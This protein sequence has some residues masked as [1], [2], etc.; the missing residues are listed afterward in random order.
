MIVREQKKLRLVNKCGAVCSETLL[1]AALLDYVRKNGLPP[2]QSHKTVFMH[3]KYPAVSVHGKKIHIHRLI[4][5]FLS[6]NLDGK[7]VD[8]INGNK[9]D[10]RVA[11]L[12][13]LTP[14]EHQR[15]TNLG[16]KQSP[17]HIAKRTASMK[18]TRYENHE[19]LEAKE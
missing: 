11:N 13:L 10:A 17:E 19:L 2:I 1:E 14:S 18:R 3:G 4:M 7:Y 12:R 9:M 6:G 5:E 16:R 8:H 15:I